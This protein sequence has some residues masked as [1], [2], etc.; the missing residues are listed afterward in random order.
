MVG[1]AMH[2]TPLGTM[3]L[4][5]RAAAFALGLALLAPAGAAAHT[6][7]VSYSRFQI[8]GSGARIQ[9]RI[10]LLELTRFPPE[11][12]W[13]TYLATHLLLRAGGEP[14]APSPVTRSADATPGWAMFRWEVTCPANADREI[15]SRLFEE[16][17]GTHLHFARVQ[18]PGAGVLERVLVPTAPTWTLARRDQRSAGTSFADDVV[19]GVEHIL[20]GW[21][22]IAFVA[23]LL[24]LSRSLRELATLVVAFTVAHS[25][26]LAL[27]VVGVL[28][29]EPAAVE[30]LIGFS[31]ALVAAEN[32]WWLG[33]RDRVIPYALVAAV[34]AA[35]DFALSGSGILPPLAWAGLALFSACHFGLL[36][37]S[38]DDG[39]LLRALVAFA[40][41]LV[42]GLGFAAT[43]MAIGLPPSRLAPALLGFNVGVEIGLLGII[44]ILWP[45]LRTLSRHRS[46]AWPLRVA[47]TGSAAI[48]GLG[49]YWIVIRNWP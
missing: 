36:A 39:G 48:L 45:L 35:A 32:G 40:F 2:V 42:H 16:V 29:P 31:A 12:D 11:H 38:G 8:T 44:A 24:I 33:G 26:T 46:G 20:T 19:L 18:T 27:A 37:V 22:H 4:R 3:G 17:L 15:E 47:G 6:R 9:V 23:A 41:G 34:V 43:L 14:C 7:S 30:I 13:N 49:L 5:H 25:L 1:R 10:P 28:R 21:A